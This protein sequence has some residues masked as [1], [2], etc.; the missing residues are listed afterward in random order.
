MTT[1]MRLQDSRGLLKNK[2]V[3]SQRERSFIHSFIRS[4]I[5]PFPHRASER[6]VWG[7]RGG[8]EGGRALFVHPR[9][10]LGIDFGLSF[11]SGLGL[12]INSG[13]GLGLGFISVFSSLQLTSPPLVSITRYVLT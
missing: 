9:F 5:S 8:G 11:N 3:F 10:G 12:G 1:E 7:G 13:F 2:G 4:F 6:A